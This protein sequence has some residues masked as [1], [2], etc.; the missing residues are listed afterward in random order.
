ME[1][2]GNIWLTARK[3]NTMG[4]CHSPHHPF[5]HIWIMFHNLQ[6]RKKKKISFAT[7][8]VW[9]GNQ[10]LGLL[11]EE[12]K[13]K[14]VSGRQRWIVHTSIPGPITEIVIFPLMLQLSLLQ[15]RTF[16]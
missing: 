16:I 7:T 12:Q 1:R 9:F 6:N 2:I 5:L 15:S 14:E 10:Q 11:S 4:I 13:V 8:I 3:F